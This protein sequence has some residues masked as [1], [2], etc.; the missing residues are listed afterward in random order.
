MRSILSVNVSV[1]ALAFALAAC[2][3]ADSPAESETAEA[4][5]PPAEEETVVEVMEAET[6]EVT[7]ISEE[8]EP[9]AGHDPAD[10]P[11]DED[12][13]HG[14]DHDHDHA[15]GE[16]HAH[17]HD[18]DHDHDHAGGHAHVHGVGDMSIVLEGAVLTVDLIAPL[19]NFGLAEDGSAGD[20]EFNAALDAEAPFVFPST[21]ARCGDP[22]R[23]ARV[24]MSGGPADGFITWT[25]NCAEPGTLA[26]VSTELI[27]SFPGFETIDVVGLKGGGETVAELSASEQRFFFD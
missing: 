10:E 14:D 3:Q 27:D 5:P 25:F 4:A 24:D 16:D 9:A 26:E 15:E 13:D 19:S 8:T 20:A 18:H 2:G 7:E 1:A 6:A 17:D 23:D 21:D 11:V 22:D 12:H